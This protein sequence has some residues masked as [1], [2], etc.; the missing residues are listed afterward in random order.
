[1]LEEKKRKQASEAG[2][3]KTLFFVSMQMV[4]LPWYQRG[5]NA[6]EL[7]R[8]TALSV[9]FQPLLSGSRKE[10]LANKRTSRASHKKHRLPYV[11]VTT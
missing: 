6:S 4:K 9:F 1:M 11:N 8:Q 10:K 3:K 5:I 7:K 2:R